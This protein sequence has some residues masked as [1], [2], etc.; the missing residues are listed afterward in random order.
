[1]EKV[2]SEDESMDDVSR[3]SKISPA[4][5]SVNL[6]AKLAEA[7]QSFHNE[8]NGDHGDKDE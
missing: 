8:N 3:I 5:A 7:L 2:N 1:V 4:A 6:N